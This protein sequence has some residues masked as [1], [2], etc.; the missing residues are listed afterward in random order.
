MHHNYI[1]VVK[2]KDTNAV[3]CLVMFCVLHNNSILGFSAVYENQIKQ[4]VITIALLTDNK[5]Q[6]DKEHSNP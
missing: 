5:R 1:L 6:Q 3:T 4:D 2:M